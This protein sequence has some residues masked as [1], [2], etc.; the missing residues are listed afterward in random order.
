MSV[1]RAK[2]ALARSCGLSVLAFQGEHRF[3]RRRAVS[4][5]SLRIPSTF[6]RRIFRVRGKCELN[7]SFLAIVSFFPRF[8]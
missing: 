6:G 5:Y 3:S 7:L 4:C 8:M 1:P 2:I